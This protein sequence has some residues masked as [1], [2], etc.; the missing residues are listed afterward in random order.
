MCQARPRI[1][2]GRE[3]LSAPDDEMS[4]MVPWHKGAYCRADVNSGAVHIVE[5]TVA[6][7]ADINVLPK[8]LRAEDDVIFGDADYTSDEYKRGSRELGVRWCVQDKRKLGQN[9]SR[10]QKKRKHFS[11]WARVE[12]IFRVIKRQFGFI[13]IRY[14]GLMK[15]AAVQVNIADGL[16]QPVPAAQVVGDNLREKS[17]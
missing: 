12:H 2:N 11:I 10:S 14:C 7:E 17:A 3:I 16:G 8:L 5:I 13:R 4:A 9:L 15:N 1:G 6:N